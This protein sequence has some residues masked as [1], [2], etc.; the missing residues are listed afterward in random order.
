MPGIFVDKWYVVQ[1]TKSLVP[2][3]FC[4][5]ASCDIL[6]IKDPSH[7]PEVVDPEIKSNLGVSQN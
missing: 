6:G 2:E 7:S 3:A 5:Q 4:T 1:S